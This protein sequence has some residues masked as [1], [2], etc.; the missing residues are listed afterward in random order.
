MTEKQMDEALIAKELT[1]ICINHLLVSYNALDG[2]LFRHQFP[3]EKKT[4]A[5]RNKG[6]FK[7]TTAEVK[8]RCYRKP[9][10]IGEEYGKRVREMNLD[11]HAP[12]KD[13]IR[14]K[15]KAIFHTYDS[16]ESKEFIE[17]AISGYEHGEC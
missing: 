11:A 8:R 12:Y 3:D 4:V 1:R 5:Y 14:R 16:P 15:A 7:A 2:Y 9:R 10:T 17:A 6:Y 13:V